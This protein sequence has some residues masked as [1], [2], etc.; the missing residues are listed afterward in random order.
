MLGIDPNMSDSPSADYFAMAVM[1][2]DDD[3][4]LGTLVHTYAGLGNL[5]NHVKYLAYL[6]Q[7]FNIVF[8]C[9]DNAGS[10]V[11]H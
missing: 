6:F 1:E 7:A 4:G 11:F 5:S 9:L 3:T 8:V 2:I 10:D